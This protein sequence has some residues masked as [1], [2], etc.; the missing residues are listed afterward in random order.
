MYMAKWM[1]LRKDCWIRPTYRIG[2]VVY[3]QWIKGCGPWNETEESLWTQHCHYF[4][5]E[6]GTQHRDRVWMV[7]RLGVATVTGIK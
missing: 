7:K 3:T 6:I 2:P 5:A 1:T 4:G